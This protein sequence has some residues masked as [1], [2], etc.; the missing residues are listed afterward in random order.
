MEASW[1][2]AEMMP[3]ESEPSGKGGTGIVRGIAAIFQKRTLIDS[4]RLP[5]SLVSQI[6]GPGPGMSPIGSLEKKAGEYAGVARYGVQ[7]RSV[8]NFAESSTTNA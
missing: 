4:L 2:V 5:G 6:I 1:N 8:S 3:G 7:S